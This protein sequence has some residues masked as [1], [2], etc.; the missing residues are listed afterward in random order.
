MEKKFSEIKQIR[1]EAEQGIHAAKTL[2][3][4]EAI[5]VRYLGRKG[6]ITQ[7]L[8]RLGSLSREERQA[9]GEAI[10]QEKA[11]VQAAVALHRETLQRQAYAQLAEREWIDVTQPGT[12]PPDGHL[13]LVTQAIR[14]ITRLFERIGFYR[15]RYPEVEWDWYAFE[16]L[17]MPEGH[18]AR[19]E[20]ETFFMDTP[21][22]PKYGRLV[23]TPHTSNGQVREMELAEL[24][25]RLIN[26]S[27]CYRRQSDVSHVPMF[28]QFEG[29]LI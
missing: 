19:D 18:P 13:H 29:L 16:S 8:G 22:H 1:R 27:K 21:A 15:R 12:P 6:V 23:L 24:P 14:E 2:A 3:E 28:H 17:N 20:W 9:L 4:L 25:I 26:I 10:N 11:A 7:K 5:E